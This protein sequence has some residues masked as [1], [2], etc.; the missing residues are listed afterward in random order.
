MTPG[1]VHC[2]FGAEGVRDGSD[3]DARAARRALAA[4]AEA[5]AHRVTLTT[6]NPRTEDPDRIL[7][8]LLAGFRRP[9][10]VRVEPDRRRAIESALSDARPGDAVLFAG[11]GREGFQILADGALP[12]DDAAVAREW[13]REHRARWRKTSA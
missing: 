7:D 4:A 10:R 8:D 2:V 9:G 6:D 12:F 3:A 13:L 11:K 5:L 1:Q